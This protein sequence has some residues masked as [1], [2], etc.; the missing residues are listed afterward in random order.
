MEES[1]RVADSIQEQV[2][3]ALA[4]HAALEV[5][6]G[7]SKSFLGRKQSGAPLDVSALRGVVSYEPGE[8]VLVARPGTRLSEIETLLDGEGQYF[9]FEPPGWGE[10]ATIGGT[11]ARSDCR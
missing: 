9:A 2:R 3:Q 8:L 7:G 4:E 11:V 1:N 10:A 5:F 6:A